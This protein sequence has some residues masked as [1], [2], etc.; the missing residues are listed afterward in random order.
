MGLNS[1]AG[2]RMAAK[3]TPDIH[4][5]RKGARFRGIPEFCT[6]T[7]S[8]RLPDD[9]AIDFDYIFAL[10]SHSLARLAKTPR[11][12]VPYLAFNNSVKSS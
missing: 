3:H 11:G 8:K 6:R 10:C 4:P 12:P 2:P 7:S 5:A 1:I 9:A